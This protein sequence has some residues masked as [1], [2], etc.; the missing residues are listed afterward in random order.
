[1]CGAA[2]GISAAFNAPIGGTLF[3]YE[4]SASFWHK[5]LTWRAFFAAMVAAYMTAFMRSGLNSN[6]TGWGQLSS[7][8]ALQPSQAVHRLLL[9]GPLTIVPHALVV[10]RARCR[11][12]QLRGV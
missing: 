8:G 9:R 4:E 1:M 12:V 11:Y 7:P 6:G 10:T 2:A 5:P 3:A